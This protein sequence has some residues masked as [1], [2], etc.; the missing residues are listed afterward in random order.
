MKFSCLHDI[1]ELTNNSHFVVK[2]EISTKTFYKI[3]T[4]LTTLQKDFGYK[5]IKNKKV[6]TPYIRRFGHLFREFN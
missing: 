5:D 2:L 6:A 3:G 1:L 4:K